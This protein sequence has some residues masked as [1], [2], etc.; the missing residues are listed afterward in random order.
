MTAERAALAA[1]VGRLRCPET[2]AAL[3]VRHLP[4]LPDDAALLTGGRHI[5]PAL[6]GIPRLLDD[7]LRAPLVTLLEAGAVQ[8]A[9]RLAL[10]WPSKAPGSRIRRRAMRDAARLLPDGVAMARLLA[11][12]SDGGRVLG[13]HASFAALLAATTPPDLAGW[14]LHR[15]CARPFLPL[16][17]LAARLLR[18]DDRVL[19]IGGGVGHSSFVLARHVGAARVTSLDTVFA[20]LHAAR[21]FNAPGIDAVCADAGRPLPFADAAFDAVVM[22]DSF[23]FVPDQAGLATETMRVL[24]PAGQVLLAHVHNG[25]HPEPY[26]GVAQPPAAY[27]ACFG[28]LAPVVLRNDRLLDQLDADGDVGLDDPALTEDVAAVESLSLVARRGAPLP[29]RQGS[30]WDAV[31]ARRTRLAPNPLLGAGTPLSGHLAAIIAPP[32][33]RA[34]DLPLGPAMDPGRASDLLRRRVLV[35]MPLGFL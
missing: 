2:G 19:E 5:Y 17:P 24:G 10:H 20:H 8:A 12:V 16:V 22:T 34:D 4:G 14:M 9:A 3:A 26:P 6:L 33:L 1:L 25:L 30:V 11:A 31:Q 32:Q 23:H 18:P 29:G 13:P 15:F 35:D 7:A 28:P 21:R 27:A